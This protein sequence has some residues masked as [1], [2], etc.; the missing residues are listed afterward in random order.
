MQNKPDIFTALCQVVTQEEFSR[1]QWEFLEKN[2]KIF[3]DT[4][5]NKLEYTSIYKDYVYILDQIIEQKLMK[6]YT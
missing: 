6:D 2:N 5:E 3:E 4:D 1:N